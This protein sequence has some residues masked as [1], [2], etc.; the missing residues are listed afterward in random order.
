MDDTSRLRA[1]VNA[2]RAA[3]LSPGEEQT[4][5]ALRATGREH[6]AQSIKRFAADRFA[7]EGRVVGQMN[8][9]ELRQFSAAMDKGDEVLKIQ[10][11]TSTLQRCSAQQ[12][13]RVVSSGP[14]R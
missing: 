14:E 7:L 10:V 2:K 4:Y 9:S 3:V 12:P 11:M 8:Q 5:R 1:E 13:A 6:E